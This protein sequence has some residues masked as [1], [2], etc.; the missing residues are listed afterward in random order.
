MQTLVNFELGFKQ[1]YCTLT[2]MLL[3]KIVLCSQFH[4]TKLINH[5]F[6]DELTPP[7]FKKMF[8]LPL[9]R[10]EFASATREMVEF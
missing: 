8:G 4:Y 1:Y 9:Q 10:G 7:P 3:T 6:Q 5:V 2:F